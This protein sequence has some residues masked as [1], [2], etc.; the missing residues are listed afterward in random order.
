MIGTSALVW[1]TSVLLVAVRVAMLFIATPL[2]GAV[3]VP[4]MARAL[5]VFG[6]AAALVGT[7]SLAP[8]DLEPLRLGAMVLHEAIV[9]GAIAAGLFIGF[10]AWHFAGRL[11]DLQIG[12]GVASLVD[13]ATKSSTPLLG[14]L[15][16]MAAA[17][18]FFAVDGHVALLR[19]LALSIEKLP[20][21]ADF[22]A[23]DFGALIAQ[24]GTCFV[25]GFVV[26][27]PIVLCLLLVDFGVAF[28]S[29]TMPQ[30]NVFVM[31]LSLKVIVGL[32]LLAV[33]VP[34]MGGNLR[35]IFE[36]MF[37]GWARLVG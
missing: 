6:L 30:M 4:A 9:G 20:P 19:V 18:V 12:F 28:M 23:L 27:A 29:R 34:L 2:F 25:F 10:A 26:V 14:S 7:T 8:G 11:L 35:R 15:L 16:S 22:A 3:P 5:L 36:S 31:S 37:D 24:F 13:I 21:S 1:A 33:I 17:V 32:V